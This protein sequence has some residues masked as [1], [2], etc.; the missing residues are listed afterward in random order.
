MTID[1]RVVRAMQHRTCPPVS[2]RGALARG[3][4]ARQGMCPCCLHTLKLKTHL[5]HYIRR[6]VTLTLLPRAHIARTGVHGLFELPY[7]I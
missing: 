5:L 2:E 3:A 6:Y 4:C 7:A 1:A